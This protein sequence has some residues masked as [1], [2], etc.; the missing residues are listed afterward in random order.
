MYIIMK[1]ITNI[2]DLKIMYMTTSIGLITFEIGQTFGLDKT[3]KN[4]DSTFK[5]ISASNYYIYSFL[6]SKYGGTAHIKFDPKDIHYFLKLNE[7]IYDDFD[8]RDKIIKK[9]N[10][11]KVVVDEFNENTVKILLG[12]GDKNKYHSLIFL[13][14]PF[15]LRI[16]DKKKLINNLND[17]LSEITNDSEQILSTITCALFI[18]YALNNIDINKW[19]EKISDDLNDLKDTEKY[20]DYINNY[21]ELNFRNNLFIQQKIEYLVHER[22]SKFL[23][24]YCNK[25]NRILTEHPKEQVI[26][27]YDTILRSRDNWENLILFGM[28]N[29][30]DN[31]NISL[32]I[33]VLYEILFGSTKVNKNLIKRFSFL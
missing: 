9:T 4:N 31:I 24:N 3:F 28:V 13:A 15:A 12:K 25:N 1:H 26:L 21:L 18:H 33:G 8:E 22:N 23:E 11:G 7:L 30:N 29:Y 20:L 16:H 19:I 10:I 2:R 32:I 17:F 6:I 5:S 14:V 27:I